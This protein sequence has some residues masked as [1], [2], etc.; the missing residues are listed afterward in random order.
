MCKDIM[1][2]KQA[3]G[4]YEKEVIPELRGWISRLEDFLNGTLGTFVPDR[5]FEITEDM[6]YQVGGRILVRTAY[7]KDMDDAGDLADYV[8]DIMDWLE[9]SRLSQE[10][11]PVTTRLSL[12]RQRLIDNNWY[13]LVPPPEVKENE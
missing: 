9:S 3:V 4:V 7:G 5:E 2:I 1:W 6:V 12:T 10:L 8:N 13:G 11:L